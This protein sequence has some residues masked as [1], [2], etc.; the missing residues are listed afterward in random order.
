MI[1][2][3]YPPWAF[4]PTSFFIQSIF[5]FFSLFIL[6]IFPSSWP[7]KTFSWPCKTPLCVCYL[8]FLI[9]QGFYIE[10]HRYRIQSPPIPVSVQLIFSFLVYPSWAVWN[11]PVIVSYISP[12]KVCYSS[13][14]SLLA[15]MQAMETSIATWVT[16]LFLFFGFYM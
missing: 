9:F 8:Y 5:I 12:K 13:L 6:F 11:Y 4:Y 7:C 2:G 15:F 3:C 16:F 14:E 10:I 1:T